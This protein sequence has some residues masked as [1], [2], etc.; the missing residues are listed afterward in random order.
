MDWNWK[1]RK[2]LSPGKISFFKMNT[3]V[4]IVILNWNGKSNVE[5]CLKSLQRISYKPVEIIVVDNASSDGS[6]DFVKKYF[7]SVR[8]ISLKKNVGYSG[9]NNAGIRASRGK[10]V[11]ILNND[12]EVN[13]RFLESLVNR[14]ELDTSIGCIQPKLLYVSDKNL[15]NAVGSFFTSTGFLYHYGYRKQSSRKQYNRSMKIYSAKG[16]AMLLRKSALEKIGLFD[17]D[18][19]I[20]FEETDL[21]HRL[22]LAGYTVIYEP[23]SVV[24]HK[25]AVDTHKQMQEYT[26]TYLSFR[27][28]I[29]SFLMNLDW[30]H[31]VSVLPMLLS[32][33]IFLVFYYLVSFRPV[34]SWA[35]ISS[36]VWNIQEFK[37]TLKKRHHVQRDIRSVSD[38]DL[39]VSIKR[40]PSPIYYYYSQLRNHTLL[41]SK[42][43]SVLTG[44]T[45][46]FPTIY[47]S[48]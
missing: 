23:M 25:E 27:N 19:F 8:V 20:Y 29:C 38:S 15:L 5:Q 18:F 35:V 13:K 30:N 2:C 10:Y 33:Y 14:M 41:A 34:L 21:C 11:L 40:D 7:P 44:P 26:I 24:Y 46:L 48:G 36:I 45:N 39:F 4:S 31:V 12:T 9:G 37:K 17:E 22:W 3:L 28:R 32:I 1:L 16:A 47:H 6:T 43:F 42:N